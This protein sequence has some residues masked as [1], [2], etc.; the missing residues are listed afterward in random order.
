MDDEEMDFMRQLGD[1]INEEL[2]NS[3]SI[4]A[5]IRNIRQ[6]GYDV[7]LVM[8]A[9]VG[10]NK[11][12]GERKRVNPPPAAIAEPGTPGSPFDQTGKVR[13]TMQDQKFLRALKIN[14]G[15]DD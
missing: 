15:D 12:R 7:F 5:V 13:L 1:A 4:A 3:D 8:E 11:R 9:S 2:S 10:F 6:A 14:T